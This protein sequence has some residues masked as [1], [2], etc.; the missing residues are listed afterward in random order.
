[1]GLHAGLRLVTIDSPADE[2]AFGGVALPLLAGRIDVGRGLGRAD[3]RAWYETT[4]GIAHALGAGTQLGLLRRSRAALAMR[5]GAQGR[6]AAA[7]ARDR[8]DA[9]L[10]AD[11]ALDAV[12]GAAGSLALGRAWALTAD[13][14]APLVLL[15]AGRSAGESFADRGPYVLSVD[16]GLALERA[17]RGGALHALRLAVELPVEASLSGPRFLALVGGSFGL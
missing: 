6:G 15:H 12:P 5:L 16:A 17:T 2:G 1:M 7:R 8:P 10:E 13:A 4:A 3:L 14:R 11:L 9:A